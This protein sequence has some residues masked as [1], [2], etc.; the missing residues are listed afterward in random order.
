[1]Q[2]AVCHLVGRDSSAIKFETAEFI[3]SVILLAETINQMKEGRKPEY[4]EKISD[5][6]LQQMPHTKTLKCKSQARLEPAL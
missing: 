4:P 5:D 6:E 2:P 1:M 3:F